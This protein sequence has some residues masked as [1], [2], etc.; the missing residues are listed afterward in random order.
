MFSYLCLCGTVLAS[1]T[2]TQ[3]VAGSNAIF[4]HIFVSVNSVE[5]LQN[6]IR[7]NSIV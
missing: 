3:E 5:F 4:L 2:L 7:K 6:F 1:L